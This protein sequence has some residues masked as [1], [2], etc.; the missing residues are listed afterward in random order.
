M[1]AAKGVALRLQVSTSE[2]PAGR[3]SYTQALIKQ[4]IARIGEVKKQWSM[5]AASWWITFNSLNHL[6]HWRL[7]VWY[8]F[9]VVFSIQAS[10]SCTGFNNGRQLNHRYKIRWENKYGSGSI[11]VKP[12]DV[13]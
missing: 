11:D 5:R 13:E 1:R 6:S 8:C 3:K 12:M 10:R 4:F 9:A 2:H 7:E